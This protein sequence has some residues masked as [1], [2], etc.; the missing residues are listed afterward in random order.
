MERIFGIRIDS[1]GATKSLNDLDSGFKKVDS[2]SGK[3]ES[4]T[5]KLSK[6]Q[7]ESAT[8]TQKVG[9]EV[10]LLKAR[11]LGMG[12]V[13]AAGGA[14]IAG[15]VKQFAAYE[16]SIAEVN[17]LLGESQ[18][19]DEYS[20][21]VRELSKQFG[22][23][24]V[25]QAKALYQVISAGASDATDATNIL[26]AANKLAIG[27][28]TDI[29]TAADGLT[30]VINAYGLES[31]EAGRVSDIL[32]STMKQGK[33]T[34]GE[35]SGSLGKVAPLASQ[36]GVGF[37]ELTAALAT[38]T[39][40]GVKTT[41]AVTQVKAALANVL[42]PSKEA[43]ELAAE[44]GINFSAS[45]LKAE[46]L[47]GFLDI[48]SEATGGSSEQL[49]KLF[50]SVEAVQAV[51]PLAGAQ[52]EKFSQILDKNKNSAGSTEEAF[53]KMTATIDFNFKQ[54]VSQASDLAV[55]FGSFLAPAINLAIDGMQ[56]M[57]RAIELV[58]IGYVELGNLQSQF[59][60]LL[61]GFNQAKE[62]V[63]GV[64]GVMDVLKGVFTDTELVGIALIRGLLIGWENLKAGTNRVILGIGHGWDLL[65]ASMTGSFKSFVL[66]VA[67]G[68]DKLPDLFGINGDSLRDFASGIGDAESA[69]NEY[70]KQLAEA[71]KAH[72]D[73]I[74]QIETI[75]DL[76]ADDAI[77]IKESTAKSKENTTAVKT[78]TGALG[79]NKGALAEAKEEAKRV[80]GVI[81]ELAGSF[82][83]FSAAIPKGGLAEFQDQ[84]ATDRLEDFNKSMNEAGAQMGAT[85]AFQEMLAKSLKEGT[86]STE[87]AIIVAN[88]YG[89]DLEKLGL[90]TKDL[91]D[92]TKTVATVMKDEW[93]RF[94]DSAFSS[95]QTFWRDGLDGTKK[96]GDSVK[97]L[98]KD[99]VSSILAQI[100]K[101]VASNVFKKLIGIVSGKPS[102][103]SIFDGIGDLFGS[104]GDKSPSGGL[105]LG[106]I[107]KS[108]GSLFGKS[109]S[110]A[111]GA[112][113][114]WTSVTTAA[115][116]LKAGALKL[117]A[118]I[119]G[120]GWAIAGVA[121]AASLLI[122]NSRDYDQ[123][124]QEDYLP[125]L[126]G[127][128]AG[129][130]IGANGATGF[131]GGNTGIFGANFGIEGSGITTQF[132]ADG[133][134]NGN[135]GFFTGSQ[136]AL[137]GFEKALR[138]A[139]FDELIDN[140][141]GTLR[142]FDKD[143]N[144]EDIKSVW[145]AYAAGLDESVAA[146]EV[147]K[148]AVENGL[149]EPSN[150]FFEQFALGFGE[151]AFQAK[152][153]L[154]AIDASF[155]DMVSS[156][157]S[158]TDALFKAISDNYGIAVEDAKFF[159]EQSGVSADQWV[160]NFTDASGDALAEIL[161]FNADGITAFESLGQAGADQAASI[162]S[163]F[164]NDLG[165]LNGFL[166]TIDLGN[167]RGQ[168]SIAGISG[169]TIPHVGDFAS[170]MTASQTV[171]FSGSAID[172]LRTVR[173]NGNEEATFSKKG[174]LERIERKLSDDR[175]L[176]DREL[177]ADLGA[178]VS[179]V[180][181]LVRQ[182]Q[183]K[184][185]SLHEA[186]Q[187]GFG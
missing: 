141:A 171:Q 39:T 71:D 72:K 102:G 150:L 62:S 105:D 163:S 86:I 88:K 78:N 68:A 110:I 142:V 121:A 66:T 164:K 21:S 11:Y 2:S 7:K 75:T 42:K 53:G 63:E 143:K 133:G 159:V 32:F 156:G 49:A 23:N 125:D 60:G 74:T 135:G 93:D 116:G 46:G 50:G 85:A 113:A 20:E 67:N 145:A 182:G 90:K 13:I 134:E 160:A 12:A 55:S 33:T 152:D 162:L 114:A 131:D 118:T 169:E 167:A 174:A 41:E 65:I 25:E 57:L 48:V 29:Q 111:K 79:E 81:D 117:V 157:M 98:F 148:T 155:D 179:S 170:A 180:N 126:L 92:E 100:T 19:I 69:T 3:V 15:S 96:F 5:K 31:S 8:A 129:S 149:I 58:G 185:S 1:K 26:T 10:D 144:V 112:S 30:S 97:D 107:G 89:L 127:V 24:N 181:Q 154:L 140:E 59:I 45:G 64:I 47:A 106:S 136:A 166:G 132:L 108:I 16:K 139:G 161:D 147:F 17:T 99:M 124:L 184:Q 94:K 34:I 28:V 178:L 61:G 165:S 91:G 40:N 4:S 130:G 146:S 18:N 172:S 51:M 76:M 37:D 187:M 103:G 73:A 176:N 123:I 122:G 77:A 38:I 168:Y 186:V 120:W 137:D 158:S 56:G 14:I 52:A 173:V 82:E 177:R 87:A 80:A 183:I 35:L 109:G 153:S 138:A 22:T 6:A 44:L 9:K 43:S 83:E 54:L 151:S 128:N 70:T 119:P 27:G 84:L 101:M 95:L 115:A 36:L 175:S 104:G